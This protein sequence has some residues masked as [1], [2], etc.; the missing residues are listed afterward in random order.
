D[1][2]Y[3]CSLI[4]HVALERPKKLTLDDSRELEPRDR[5][6][7]HQKVHNEKTRADAP[8]LTPEALQH[9]RFRVTRA[10]PRPPCNRRRERSRSDRHP[11]R[12]TSHE[13]VARGY[14]SSVR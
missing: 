14:R 11:W 7:K 12:G 2:A 6:E 1:G 3:Q 9:G 4:L 13:S 10:A 5:H 8:K